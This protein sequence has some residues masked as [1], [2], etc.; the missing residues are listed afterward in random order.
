MATSAEFNILPAY[1]PSD[2]LCLLCKELWVLA[3]RSINK[4]IVAVTLRSG[5]SNKLFIS[6]RGKYG[7]LFQRQTTLSVS[8][9][10]APYPGAIYIPPLLW[11]L[12]SEHLCPQ[13]ESWSVPGE[14]SS[15]LF[16]LLGAMQILLIWKEQADLS[17]MII[18]APNPLAAR[19]SFF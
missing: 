16:T 4:C 5:C 1:T 17:N 2:F 7:C 6:S 14:N 18:G 11:L 13:G 9:Q 8:F 19:W 15:T 10:L 12:T 3:K